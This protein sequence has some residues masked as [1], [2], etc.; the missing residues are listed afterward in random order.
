MPSC[1]YKYI[2]IVQIAMDSIYTKLQYQYVLTI[3]Y[4][5]SVNSY[6]LYFHYVEIVR[7]S[8]IYS[9]YCK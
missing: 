5:H 6:I 4:L 1:N 3:C 7:L 9:T 2:Y 8:T